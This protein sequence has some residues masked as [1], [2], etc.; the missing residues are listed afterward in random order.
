MHQDENS[1]AII[2]MSGRFPGA[3]DDLDAFWQNLANGVES[4]RRFSKEELLEMGIDEHLIDNPRFVAA[5]AILDDV[6]RFDAPFFDFSPREAQ[7]LDPQHRLFLESSWHALEHAGYVPN[8]VPGRVGVYAG[9]ALSAYMFRNLKSNPGFIESVGTFKTMLANDK[10]FLATRVSYKFG[11][12]GA[13]LNVNTLCSS[14]AA[15]IAMACDSLVNYQN[16]VALAGGVSLQLTRN[17][18]YFYQEGNIGAADG[19]CRAFDEKAS[20]TVSG[21]GLGVVILKRLE[22]ALADDDNI[23]AVIR[24]WAINND[25]ADKSSYTA[26]SVD[27]QAE[28]ITEALEMADIDA[29]DVSYVEAH[30]TGT[31]LGDPIEIAGLTQAYRRFTDKNQ[32]CAIGSVKTNIGHLVTAGGVAS[33][34]KTVL[35]MQNKTIPQSL[36]FD[37]PNPKI[38]FAHSP[39]TV[40]SRTQPWLVEEQKPRIA[41]LSS[42]GIGGTNVHLVIEEAPQRAEQAPAPEAE[43]GPYILP[44]SAKSPWSLEQNAQR[45]AQQLKVQPH[46]LQAVAHTLQT[47]RASFDYRHVVVAQSTEDAIAKLS[48]EALDEVFFAQAKNNSL[49]NVFM[50]SGQGS[51]YSGALQGLYGR[52]QAYTEAVDACLAVPGLPQQV[53]GLLFGESGIDPVLANETRYAQPLLFIYEYAMSKQLM[54]LGCKPAALIGH[55]LG[56]FVAACI[57]EVMSLE[58][59]L[60]LVIARGDI[61]H[62]AAPGAMLSVA[63]SEQALK[64][65]LSPALSIAAVNGPNLCVVSGPEEEVE[66]LEAQLQAEQVQSTR[67]QTE[68]AFHSVMMEPLLAQFQARCEAITYQPPIYPLISNVSGELLSEIDAHYWVRHLREP[69]QFAA[70]M[71]TVA[72][73]FRPLLIEVGPGEALAKMARMNMA[74]GTSCIACYPVA[75]RAEHGWAQFNQA[76]ARL[77]LAGVEPRWSCLYTNQPHR[78]TLPGY[79]FERHSYW[80]D[81]RPGGLAAAQPDVIVPP[82]S[83][84]NEQ[85][86]PGPLA[87][88]TLKIDLQD[89]AD[90]DAILDILQTAQAQISALH[91]NNSDAEIGLTC[92]STEPDQLP[93]PSLGDNP[94]QFVNA[95]FVPATEPLHLSLVKSWQ[96]ALGIREIGIHDD[97]FELGGHSLIA[98]ALANDLINEF[99]VEIPLVELLEHP[100]VAKLAELI[101]RHQWLNQADSESSDDSYEEERI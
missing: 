98:A 88:M 92:V 31:Q 19:H 86:L 7:L 14:S 12:K 21:S 38:D 66:L 52:M 42:F 34:I 83:A 18:A 101:E 17:E 36:N 23:L 45:L 71:D 6:D 59:A 77:W 73:E 53:R 60:Q 100:T 74:P 97:F 51:Q 44:V 9:S 76:V 54:A 62:Q 80:V 99:G 68:K 11:F 94:R 10:D 58:D 8:K 78:V 93:Q 20:G 32:Y 5:D 84:L 70:G 82:Q 2:G 69:V 3:G 43:S 65:R 33:L 15:A 46:N 24:G 22:D 13:S 29:G 57:A 25:G 30:G 90:N 37:K 26:P 48:G 72:Q 67:L 95:S 85:T 55:S 27:G 96:K 28:V 89:G 39:F 56:E 49:D 40:A 79:A 81:E 41:G 4:V 61:M 63:M 87:A 50:F 47:A 16:D 35:A 64:A 1:I 91:Q 75:R